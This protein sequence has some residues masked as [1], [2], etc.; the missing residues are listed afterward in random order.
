MITNEER[1]RVAAKLRNVEI[2]DLRPYGGYS[3]HLGEAIGNCVR[4]VSG[5]DFLVEDGLNRLADLIEPEE[6]TCKMEPSFITPSTLDNIQEYTCSKC[7]KQTLSEVLGDDED[8][9]KYC[10]YCGAKV[11]ENLWE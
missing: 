1:R 8:V 9:P 10:S 2:E 11:P 3:V 7:G 5:F 4:L 6:F